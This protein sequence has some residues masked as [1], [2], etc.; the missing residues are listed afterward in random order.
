MNRKNKKGELE[1]QRIEC[2]AC[3]RH[4]AFKQAHLDSLDTGYGCSIDECPHCNR[5]CCWIHKL[6]TLGDASA[7]ARSN[8]DASG[9]LSV[10]S[11]TRTD[12]EREDTA[13]QRS[14]HTPLATVTAYQRSLTPPLA[15][16]PNPDSDVEREN[17]LYRPNLHT[18]LPPQAIPNPDF[19][20]DAVQ[21]SS[22]PEELNVN[23]PE[24]GQVLNTVQPHEYTSDAEEILE[25][26]PSDRWLSGASVG[27]FELRE[28]EDT[29]EE[30][31][32]T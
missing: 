10:P 4:A 12:V 5:R 21:D 25:S 15:A 9:D 20:V 13:Y 11:I 3:R 22:E 18:P 24:L 16:V 27:F 30:V 17:I 7:C 6:I 32:D 28:S 19:D 26:Q 29:P 2:P 23:T 31:D 14:L 8:R 1:M